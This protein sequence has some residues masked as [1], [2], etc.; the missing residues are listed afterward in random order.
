LEL[1]LR[2]RWER[3]CAGRGLAP[4]VAGDLFQQIEEMY[5]RPPRAYHD[6][7]HVG[8]CLRAAD[9]LVEAPLDWRIE[10][11]IWMHDCVYQPLAQDNEERSAEAAAEFAGRLGGAGE[12]AAAVRRLLLATRHVAP[13]ADADEA[14]VADADLSIL[15]AEEPEYDAYAAAIRDEYAAGPGRAVPGGAAT[16]RGADAGAAGD[17]HDGPRPG[18]LGAGRAREPGTRARPGGGVSLAR[19]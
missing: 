15:A 6:L 5:A 9:A 12:D 16:V 14:V 7:G 3:L 17:L 11:V 8:A 13:P 19:G 2:E 18:P 1:R 4:H 10:L